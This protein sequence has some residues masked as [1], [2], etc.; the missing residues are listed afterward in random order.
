[1]KDGFVKC[2]AAGM[3]TVLAHPVKNADQ[4]IKVIKEQDKEDVKILVFPEL[5]MSG[6]TCQDLF[7]QQSLLDSCKNELLRVMEETK[8]TDVFACVGLPFLYDNQVYNVA[9][10]IQRG[11][12]LGLVPK[13]Y[14]PN[15]GDVNE[16]R[17]FAEAPKKN[18]QIDFAGEQ[19][20]FGTKLLFT[21]PNGLVIGCEI[22]EDMWA[23]MSP[24]TVHALAGANVIVNPAAS[25]EA[26]GK[27]DLRRQ[28]I[29]ANSMRMCCGYIYASAGVGESSTDAVYGGH[30]V[31]AENGEILAEGKLYQA[32]KVS[33]EIDIAMLMELRRRNTSFTQMDT[34]EY[35]KIPF[36]FEE[37]ETSLT[38]VYQ[39]QPF[40]YLKDGSY[41]ACLQEMFDAQVYALARRMSQIQCK[42]AVLGLSGGLDSTLAILVMAKAFDVLGLERSGI[43]AVTM[44]CFG[45][46]SRTYDN[47]CLLAKELGATLKEVPIKKAIL[48]HFEDIGQEIDNHDVTYENAQARERTQVIMDMA[49]QCNGLVIGTGDLSEL[50]LGWAT[51]NGDHM[52]MYAVNA[53]VPKT[54]IRF[55]VEDLA[56]VWGSD[57]LKNVLLDILDTPVSP[58]LLPPVD[59]A[60]AQKTED[61]VGP[62]ELHDFFLYHMFMYGSAPEKIFRIATYTF[63]SEYD[64]ATILK[65]QKIFYRRFFTQQFKRSCMPDGPKVTSISFSPRTSLHM[66][67][68]AH[69]ALWLEQLEQIHI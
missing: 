45:T 54:V 26:G 7:F 36:S 31:I 28:V 38:R 27:Q 51:Y 58:E 1:M 65:W 4:I 23:P 64:K 5:C 68:D 19:V 13:T 11:R 29:S 3:Q 63:A 2:A 34:S 30:R 33:S 16:S 21:G 24:A 66:P 62:Y 18:M 22:C 10:L 53:S 50:A 49:N 8:K 15:Y 14:I 47:A 32:E 60:I 20:Y 69:S 37:K 61:L 35:V 56:N 55:M 40:L 46:T 12:L 41:H 67:S 43:L 25:T 52:S 6:Y 9:A 44:P 42:T 48:Q 59:D 17:Y 39:K 57:T